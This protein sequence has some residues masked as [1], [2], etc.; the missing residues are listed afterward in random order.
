MSVV[1]YARSV[2]EEEALTGAV[3]SQ[4]VA[5]WLRE[6]SPAA[7]VRM[8][9]VSACLA[10]AEARGGGGR[11][12]R[13]TAEGGGGEGE[14]EGGGGGG[15][16]EGDASGGVQGFP[17]NVLRSRAVECAAS[18]LVFYVDAGKACLPAVLIRVFCLSVFLISVCRCYCKQ[19][20]WTVWLARHLYPPG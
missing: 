1:L 12:E 6:R 13:G 8:L 2:E 7:E 5:G 14:R 10:E 15:R 11:G 9:V 19:S 3:R 18:D 16:G 20:V 17:V 4:A